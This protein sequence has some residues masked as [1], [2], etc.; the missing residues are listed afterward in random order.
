MIWIFISCNEPSLPV[1]ES[2]PVEEEQ[3]QLG[4]PKGPPT[5]NTQNNNQPPPMMSLQMP[6]MATNIPLMNANAGPPMMNS[7]ASPPML[8]LPAPDASPFHG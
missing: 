8:T 4:Q 6:M 1:E 2:N 5:H 3:R 7:I